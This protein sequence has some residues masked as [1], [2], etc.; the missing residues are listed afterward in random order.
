M[1]PVVFKVTCP[2]TTPGQ[3]LKLVGST[4]QLGSWNPQT[5]LTF[6][7][8]LA[9]FPVWKAGILIDPAQITNLQSTIEYKYVLVNLNQP[10]DYIW[11]TFAGNR[12]LNLN[13][14]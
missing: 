5:G 6:F 2:N 4:A 11:E 12:K 13:S 9:E 10:G 8:T 14:G 3:V 1:I 7:T